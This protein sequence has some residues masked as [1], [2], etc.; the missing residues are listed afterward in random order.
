VRFDAEGR[1]EA[2][3]GREKGP[4]KLAEPHGLA[5]GKDGLLYVADNGN[6]RVAVFTRDGG[7]VRAWSVPG[8]RREVMSEP[9]L[10]LDAS[11]RVWVS[12]PLEGEVRGYAPDGK[13]LATA[14]GKDQPE[15][16]RFEH[17]SGVALLP[18]GR[19]AVADFE[20]RLVV[21]SLPK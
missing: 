18:D 9:Y 3:W 15:G 10:A 8:W 20:G 1:K 21:I 11:G 16:R 12:V 6:G 17:P 14:R 5:L 19:L 4:G 13:L 2:E 7:F